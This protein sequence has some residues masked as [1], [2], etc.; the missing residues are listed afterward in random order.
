M[1][2]TCVVGADVVVMSFSFAV[3][4][5]GSSFQWTQYKINAR[6]GHVP[7]ML[8]SIYYDLVFVHIT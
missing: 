7:S 6:R 3:A 2:Y 1:V 4:R 5:R 8:A